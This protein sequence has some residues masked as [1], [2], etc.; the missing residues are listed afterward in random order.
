MNAIEIQNLNIDFGHFKIEELNLCVRKGAITGL[1]GAN[2]AGKTTIIKTI[3][4]AQNANGGSIL[5]N[6]KKFAGNEVE[7]LSSVACVFDGIKFNPAA[8]LRKLVKIY[9]S[10][11]AGFNEDKFWRLADK[12]S[13]PH[14]LK[15]AKFSFGM[16]K[17]LNFILALCQGAETLIL[18]EPTSG[19]DP[20]DRNEITTLLQ[21]YMLDENHSVLFSTHITED[22]DKIADYIVMLDG[23]K[24]MFDSDKESLIE[25]YRI[26]RAPTL[27][28][29]LQAVAIGV[30]QD[31]F[32]YTFITKN[33]E[34]SGEN[35]Q[36]RVPTVEELFVHII[37]QRKAG[38]NSVNNA[39]NYKDIF[40]I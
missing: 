33:T 35:L 10:V 17:K 18:D 1:I 11:Y 2:G 6:G 9:R 15:V 27:T 3:M 32:G 31:M 7:I 13:L 14:E 39:D 36:V 23:G 22:L 21:E 12:F 4:R 30:V 38:G 28:P 37:N 26:V 20:F 5:Y 34:L 8:N 40:G 29:E 19:V 24:V 16:Q 25:K